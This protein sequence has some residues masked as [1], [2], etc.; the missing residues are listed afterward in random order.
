M[1]PP[2]ESGRL[3]GVKVKVRKVKVKVN[4]PA[5]GGRLVGVELKVKK[6]K[7]ESESESTCRR[8]ASCRSG[9]KSKN[10]ES[11]S[12]SDST[13]R[14]WASCRSGWRDCEAGSPPLRLP[15]GQ[16]SAQP[17]DSEDGDNGADDRDDFV[18]CV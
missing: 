12:E 3:V 15:E 14:K 1:N 10:S 7:V 4:P 6:V 5:K 9:S 18:V 8:W 11:E 16:C 2:A 13:C 17:E